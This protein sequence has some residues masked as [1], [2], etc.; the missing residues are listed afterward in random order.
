M[1][2]ASC[3]THPPG[4]RQPAHQDPGSPP[5]RSS[6]PSPQGVQG[7]RPPQPVPGETVGGGHLRSHPPTP[8]PL[9]APGEDTAR[10]EH[11]SKAIFKPVKV[12]LSSESP[13]GTQFN[14]P[15]HHQK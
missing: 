13:L 15:S 3:C 2:G 5:T 9:P 1:L 11:S 12:E 4:P 10:K 7:Q 6:L 14:R 8:S